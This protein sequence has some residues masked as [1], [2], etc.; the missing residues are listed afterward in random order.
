MLKNWCKLK[1]KAK[2]S[3]NI[4]QEESFGFIVAWA[5]TFSANLGAMNSNKMLGSAFAHVQRRVDGQQAF[6]GMTQ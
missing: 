5:E 1:I 6:D 4:E 3:K 2:K